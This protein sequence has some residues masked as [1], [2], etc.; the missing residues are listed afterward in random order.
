MPEAVQVF[1]KPPDPSALRA[2]LEGRG[3]DDPQAIDRRLRTAES[4]LAAE[5]E[6]PRKVVNRDVERAA[7]DLEGIVRGELGRDG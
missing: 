1:I 6:F 3:T 7:R 4:E 5:H 2:R